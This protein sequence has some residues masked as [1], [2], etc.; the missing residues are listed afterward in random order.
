MRSYETDIKLKQQTPIIHF[1]YGQH[2][3]TLRANEVN[4]KLVC[5]T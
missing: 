3:A 4:L 1:Q 5:F 2:G